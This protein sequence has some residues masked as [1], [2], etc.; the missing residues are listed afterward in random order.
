LFKK[1]LLTSASAI[2]LSAGV[3]LPA[4]AQGA[5][6]DIVVTARK[7][8]ESLQDVPVAVSALGE[9]QL[10]E[11][12]VDV[13]TDYLVQMPGITAGGSGPG[14]NTI[15]I[16][17][18]ASTTPN[19]TTAGVAGLAPNVALY[20]DEQP[21]TQPGRNLDVYAVDM[22]RVEVL[23]GPQGTLFGASSQAGVV[24]LITNKP[25]IGE[26]SN[27][28][29]FEASF[30]PE[31][32]PSSKVELVTNFPVNERFALRTVVYA[33]QQGGY[34]DNVASTDEVS[35]KDSARFRYGNDTDGTVRS[36][37]V[38]V[39]TVRNGFQGVQGGVDLTG[40]TAP[41]ADNT[42]IASDDI[43]ETDYSGVRI[44]GKYEAENGVNVLVSVT[45][46]KLEADGVFFD[47]PSKG[48]Y[49]I[50]RFQNDTMTDEFTNVNWTFEG[51]LGGLQ[52]IYTGALTER[53]TDQLV[54][55]TDYVFVGQ[56]LPHYVCDTSVSYPNA[57][58]NA[59]DGL[60]D[61]TTTGTPT[62]D[63]GTPES[64]VT[65]YNDLT[66]QS[67]EIRFSGA[68]TDT[69]DATFGVFMSEL[70]LKERNDFVYYG[71]TSKAYFPNPLS[72]VPTSGIS[73][74]GAWPANTIFRNDITRTD[75]QLGVFGEA[76]FDIVPD[77]WT[78]TLGARYYD[79]ETDLTGAA[80]P[81]F[82]GKDNDT[83]NS[84]TPSAFAPTSHNLTEKF[85]VAG[86][87]GIDKAEADGTIVKL[88]LSYTPDAN[89][90]YFATY[91]EG[92]RPGILNRPGGASPDNSDY[93]VPFGVDT[94]E[95]KNYE[96]GWKITSDNRRLRFN[97]SAFFVQIEKMQT[98]IF[99]PSIANLFFS[100]N[101]AD[102]E[103]VGVEGDI[104]YIPENMS[105]LTL[106]GA[107]SLLDTEVTK[108]L[109]PTE[110]VDE[111]ASL[112]YAPEMQFNIRARYEWDF[113]GGLMAHVMPSIV[114]TDEQYSDIIKI[115]RDKIDSYTMVNISAG[116]SADNWSG[117]I[118]VDNATDEYAELARNYVNDVERV[119]PARPLTIGVRFAR[120]F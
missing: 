88:G 89:K 27:Q 14:Q 21:L 81:G 77:L 12:G 104:T 66:N 115:N 94:D 18:V 24:R 117:E 22:E 74:T 87:A 78:V 19:L 112:A 61:Y 2:T 36:N 53:E 98:T 92:F 84:A 107:F 35:M 62:G 106:T 55:Y 23:S 69:V 118:Y 29:R 57:V 15:Y 33:D 11:L 82:G 3:T 96:F 90:L 105:N 101:A 1:H 17:G 99:D 5:I 93:A 111:G 60:A 34:I 16:R 13:F 109:V 49:N 120:D 46:Q 67:H 7:K 47:D 31:G 110:D 54:D 102:A 116:V 86:D 25:V 44:S 56:Y 28:G 64:A 6:D 10:D 30:T 75:D 91:S 37:G 4:M 65:A 72:S 113:G 103:V 68:I 26:Y 95:M 83:S 48:D 58:I 73:R 20:L 52:A 63:C 43:N 9:K 40:V 97:G 108:V 42:D 32:D 51:E 85:S 45:S 76:N 38:R 79:V 59:S 71:A 39:M 119:T 80:T 114:Y 41:F 8:S 70:E 50:S 100:E